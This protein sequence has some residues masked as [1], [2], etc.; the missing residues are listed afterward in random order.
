MPRRAIYRDLHGKKADL[1]KAYSVVGQRG[2]LKV[3]L[4][5]ESPAEAP[6]PA[7]EKVL[8][9]P[10]VKK[11]DEQAKLAQPLE[12]KPEASQSKMPEVMANDKESTKPLKTK[13]ATTT[14]KKSTKKTT[15]K[16]RGRPRKTKKVEDQ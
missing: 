5:V 14:T 12:K 9:A 8:K 1:T 16:R 7:T 13:K 4:K 10:V 3:D 6:K 2:N 11:E 15:A